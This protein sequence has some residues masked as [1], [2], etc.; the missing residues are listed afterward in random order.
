[1]KRSF[2][3]SSAF[4]FA[5]NTIFRSKSGSSLK[6]RFYGTTVKKGGD[7]VPLGLRFWASVFVPFGMAFVTAE[8]FLKDGSNGETPKE[9]IGI[10]LPIG[11]QK[12]LSS[13]YKS[14]KRG[15]DVK[16]FCRSVR[17]LREKLISWGYDPISPQITA[18]L[19][20]ISR[21][22]AESSKEIAVEDLREQF[23]TLTKKPHVGK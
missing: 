19:L 22:Y 13:D 3:S 23:H 4:L 12:T 2:L 20:L 6:G 15:G 21:A 10:Y 5:R 17:E 7:F 1:M 9:F 8:L 18:C 16:E 11:L 14:F